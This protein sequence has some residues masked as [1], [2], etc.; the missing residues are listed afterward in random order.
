LTF[1]AKSAIS[2]AMTAETRPGATCIIEI[3]TG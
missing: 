2:H 3:I 1:S